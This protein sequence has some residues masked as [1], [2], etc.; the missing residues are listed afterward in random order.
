MN[1]FHPVFQ[2][3]QYHHLKAKKISMIHK[4]GGRDCMK[5]FCESLEKHAM[6]IINVKKKK[7]KL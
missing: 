3:L 1:I 4:V 5:K 7:I 2:Y 6:R